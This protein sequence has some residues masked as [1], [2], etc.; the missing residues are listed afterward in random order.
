MPKLMRVI[1]ILVWLLAFAWTALGLATAADVVGDKALADGIKTGVDGVASELKLGEIEGYSLPAFVLASG[2]P[3]LVIASFFIW[4]NTRAIGAR[5]SDAAEDAGAEPGKRMPSARTMR[6]EALA[7]SFV[8]FAAVFLLWNNRDLEIIIYPL[9]LFV[10]F[11]HEAGHA[12][13]SL[14]TGGQVREFVVNANGS[15]Y[16]VTAGGN[17]A[18]VLPAGYLGAALFGSLLY[19]LS[20]LASRWLSVLGVALGVILIGLSAVYARPDAN[21]MPLALLI[22]LGYGTVIVLLG[23]KAPRVINQFVLCTLAMMVALE[24]VLDLWLLVQNPDAGLGAVNNDAAAFA[25]QVTPLLPASVV[26]LMWAGI[27][28]AMLAAAIYIGTLKPLRKEIGAAVA[29]ES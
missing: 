18:L 28:V 22:G 2:L 16:A 13:A 4:R 15:G 5:N 8:A 24:A 6:R 17:A 23:A 21:G 7:V 1:W 14:L 25:E 29:A 19:L 3:L 10:T 9:R 11:V 27:A 20:N 26:A 12:L